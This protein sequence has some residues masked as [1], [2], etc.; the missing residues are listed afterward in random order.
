M[1]MEAN[2]D[3]RGRSYSYNPSSVSSDM[4][5][6]EGMGAGYTMSVKTQQQGI[7]YCSATNLFYCGVNQ[8]QKYVVR[9]LL[10]VKRGWVFLPPPTSA[11]FKIED[12]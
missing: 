2:T 5:V 8:T 12:M 11:M 10:L 3:V 6:K 1:I 4:V 9:R 7:F